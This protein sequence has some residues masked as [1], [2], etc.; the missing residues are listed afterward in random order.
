MKQLN[1][2]LRI[3]GE[4]VQKPRCVLINNNNN[5]NHHNHNNRNNSTNSNPR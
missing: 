3:S 2:S 1:V 5:N 4:V